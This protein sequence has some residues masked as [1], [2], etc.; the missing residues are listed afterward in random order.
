MANS[1][2]Q[3]PTL[4]SL[5]PSVDPD[6]RRSFDILKAFFA[7]VS[8]NG[9]FG[10]ATV[11]QTVIQQTGGTGTGGGSSTPSIVNPPSPP[12]ITGLTVTGAFATIIVSWNDP[13]Y[14][15]YGYIQVWR[16]TT[17]DLGAAVYVGESS[18]FMYCDNPPNSDTSATYYYWARVVSYTGLQGPWSGV[19]GVAG[20]TATNPA[21]ALQNLSS[22]IP[23][24]LIEAGTIVGNK[25][26]G[27]TISG[28]LLAATNII[29]GTAQIDDGV[30]TNAKIAS[31]DA[32]KITSGTLSSSVIAAGSIN[33]DT[34]EAGTITT[35]H[36]VADAITVKSYNEGDF[37]CAGGEAYV[38]VV[39]TN[40]AVTMKT[41]SAIIVFADLIETATASRYDIIRAAGGVTQVIKSTGVPYM[42]TVGSGENIWSG[43]IVLPQWNVAVV[44]Q[45]AEGVFG[46]MTDYTR[47][48]GGSTAAYS[49]YGGT[50]GQ[51]GQG[52][53]QSFKVG[54]GGYTLAS[55]VLKM[56]KVGNPTDYL[57]FTIEDALSG[58][59]ILASG[60]ITMASLPASKGPVTLTFQN[61]GAVAA[62]TTYYCKLQRVSDPVSKALSGYDA[63]NY[64]QVY[65]YG[66]NFVS[67][68]GMLTKSSGAW[69]Q[70]SIDLR[71]QTMAQI[72][73]GMQ[74][75]YS[76][77]AYPPAAQDGFLNTDYLSGKL[78]VLQMLR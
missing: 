72:T 42:I 24:G 23:G 53:G 47:S 38:D 39:V 13:G 43:N 62:N 50:G 7:A 6:V 33:A 21:Y 15:D 60:T 25:I 76:M 40:P 71:F 12:G 57:Y 34:I 28:D 27:G 18:S 61:P 49:F 11:Q 63:T 66:T 4:P 77:R 54:S 64:A 58:G 46:P 67:G 55:V 26:V 10:A 48:T 19:H 32:G 3:I 45:I 30:I 9:G 78:T 65:S 17:D 29:T 41:G 75:T 59:N 68:L 31:L 52:I 22:G 69:T 51:S 73:D 14:A 37:D 35:D 8:A 44:D 1:T 70:G 2:V 16:S 74:W 36:L 20:S 56:R 5:G